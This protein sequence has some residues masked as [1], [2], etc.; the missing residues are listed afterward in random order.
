M[1]GIYGDKPMRG[2]KNAWEPI[3]RR[4]DHHIHG[5]RSLPPTNAPIPFKLGRTH[6]PTQ[7]HVRLHLH[8]LHPPGA[9]VI[10]GAIRFVDFF[11]RWGAG[12]NNL[13][14]LMSTTR[15]F[16]NPNSIKRLRRRYN[17]EY[18]DSDSMDGFFGVGYI[19][20]QLFTVSIGVVGGLLAVELLFR[21]TPSLIHIDPPARKRRA[22][23][24]WARNSY[25][26]NMFMVYMIGLNRVHG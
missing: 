9:R 23:F 13:P 8:P 3:T 16:N 17:T 25:S 12:T 21:L 24:V 1:G 19:M 26:L 10:R 15:C 4:L 11:F 5:F 2:R 22:K 18:D 7:L 20:H 14:L 6:L